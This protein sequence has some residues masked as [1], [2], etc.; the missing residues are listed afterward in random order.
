MS[1][2]ILAGLGLYA[3]TRPRV[4]HSALTSLGVITD[5]YQLVLDPVGLLP[6]LEIT[7]VSVLEDPVVGGYPKI[8]ITLKANSASPILGDFVRIIDED[9]NAVVGLKKDWYGVPSGQT[10]V[11]KFDAY[12]DWSMAMPNRVWNLRIEVGTN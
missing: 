11:V 2:L 10:W 3:L 6:A 12:D 4:S 9:T 5:T 7:S 8:W 1:A